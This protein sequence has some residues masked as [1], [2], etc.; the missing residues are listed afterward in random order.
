[1]QEQDR[2]EQATP[3]KLEESKKRGEV[4]RSTEVSTFALAAALLIVLLSGGA[5]AW[6]SVCRSSEALFLQAA[7]SDDILAPLGQFVHAWLSITLPVGL[8]GIG[9]AIAANIL[10]TGPVFSFDP[11]TPRF[12][13]INPIAGLRRLFTRKLLIDTGKSILKLIVLGA[14]LYLFFK[15]TWQALGA[16]IGASPEGQLQFLARR[17]S[18]LLLQLVLTLLV[19]ALIDWVLVRLQFRRQMMMSRHEVKEETRRRE[20]DPYIRA[21]LRELQR[22]NLKQSRSLGRIPESDVLITN[23]DHI[24]IALRYVRGEMNAPHVI[25]KG[26]DLW[27]ER[28]RTVARLHGIPILERRGLAR[29]LWRHGAVDRPIPTEAYVDV[30]R[31][32]AELGADRRSRPARYEVAR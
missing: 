11:L 4:A 13:R 16:V 1:M 20:G 19:L 12:E 8:V 18:K 29:Q 14:V 28:M 26:T 15:A 10:Q 25:A 5:A 31:L 30:A 9:A 22:E 2:T 23:P 27:V 24:A 6:E 21:R 32:Y 7:S 17:G 3:F